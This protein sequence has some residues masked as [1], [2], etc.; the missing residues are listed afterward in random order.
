ME[1]TLC[2]LKPS[3]VERGLMG[4][5]INRIEKKGLIICG[6]TRKYFANITHIL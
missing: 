4:E 1:R 5:I 2:I 6:M 3:A